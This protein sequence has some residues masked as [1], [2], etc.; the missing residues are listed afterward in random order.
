MLIHEKSCQKTQ[1]EPPRPASLTQPR[2]PQSS[3]SQSKF[4][5]N[6]PSNPTSFVNQPSKIIQNAGKQIQSSKNNYSALRTAQKPPPAQNLMQNPNSYSDFNQKIPTKVNTLKRPASKMQIP[7]YAASGRDD[8]VECRKCRRKFNPDR[9]QKHQSVCIGPI[10]E[11]VEKPVPKVQKKR[12]VGVPLWKKQHLDFINNVRYAKKMT[13]VQKAGGDIRMIKPPVQ[14][15]D[16][17]SDYKQCPYCSR[18]FSEQVAERH[19]PNCK[20]IINK[21]KPPPRPIGK[22]STTMKAPSNPTS[23][24]CNRCGSKV[25]PSTRKCG[26][27]R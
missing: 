13:V 16:P 15:Y 10:N 24:Y 1:N 14:H 18:K 21:P 5:E 23:G 19:I 6:K 3:N 25:H 17:A 7:E 26:F 22:S 2:K 9:I 11:F 20:N 8:R 12:K 4:A 27:C